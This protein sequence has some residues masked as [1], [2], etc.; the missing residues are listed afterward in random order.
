[1]KTSSAIHHK[2]LEYI[3]GSLTAAE[4][5]ALEQQLK[6]DLALR[7]RLKELQASHTTLRTALP[8]EQP[9]RDFTLKVM[10][11]LNYAPSQE[12]AQPIRKSILLLAG[13]LIAAVGTAILMASGFF[14]SVTTTLDLNAMKPADLVKDTVPTLNINARILVNAVIIGNI[15]I[16]FIVLDRTVLKPF[17]QKRLSS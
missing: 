11:N 1:M 3:D 10:E 16:A 14:D 9:S 5:L 17:F 7:A 13:A 6:T 8:R 2:L 15:V 12:A 4:A